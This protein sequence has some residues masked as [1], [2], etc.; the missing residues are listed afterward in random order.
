MNESAWLIAAVPAPVV[1][2]K[3]ELLPL[4]A[5]H[6]MLLRRF[7]SAFVTGEEIKA[8]DL[9]FSVL[10]CSGTYEDGCKI[11][12]DD[13]MARE[14]EAWG[15][16]LARGP[17]R[18]LRRRAN[19]TFDFFAAV[20]RFSDYLT[21]GGFGA[22]S[23]DLI[24][25]CLPKHQRDDSGPVGSPGEFIYICAFMADLS[26]N[27]SEAA[28]FPYLLGRHLLAANAE[29]QGGITV[30]SAAE[31]REENKRLQELTA[32]PDMDAIRAA[33]AKGTQ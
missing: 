20:K 25:L 30:K 17:K 7:S 15:K 3:L 27:F 5:G 29:R 9:F 21:S 4:S 23:D 8:S 31:W 1:C 13:K 19:V 11:R 14:L 2:C 16:E 18:F 28:N 22:E 26:M 24:P 12:L 10:I 6:L 32:N 33:M